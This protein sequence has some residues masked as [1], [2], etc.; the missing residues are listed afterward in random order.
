MDR[1][2]YDGPVLSYGR[3]IC[4]WHGETMAESERRAISNLAYQFKKKNNKIA[5]CGGICLPGKVEKI[6]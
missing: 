2:V 5:G 6:G 3:F 4:D 1:Y